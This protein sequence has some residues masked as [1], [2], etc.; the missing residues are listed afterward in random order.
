MA[1]KKLWLRS[2]NCDLDLG[3]TTLGL[4]QQ[5]YEILSR[6]NIRVESYSLIAQTLI[7]S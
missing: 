7:F 4:S 5:L 3:E 1:R 2:V 6:S